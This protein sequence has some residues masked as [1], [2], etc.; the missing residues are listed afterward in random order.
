VNRPPAGDPAPLDR[1][2]RDQWGRVLAVLVRLLGDVDA[3][4]EAAAEAFAAAAERWPRD[5]TPTNPGSW[6]ITTAR[7]RAVDRARR[8]R[9]LAAKTEL[10]RAWHR[11]E[12]GQGDVVATDI[13]DERLELIFTCCH[14]ALAVE[15]QV[16]LTLRAVGGLAT[17]QIAR[18]F[19]VPEATMAQRLLRAKRKIRAAGIPFR[20]PPRHL[21]PERLDAVLAVIYLIFNE[22]YGGK[23]DLDGEALWLGTALADLLPEEAEVHGL[24]ALML[25]NDSRR[26]ARTCDGETVL[27]ADQDRLRWD[28]GQLTA[29]RRALDRALTLAGPYQ[30]GPY[31]LQALVASLHATDPPDWQ[32]IAILYTEL[33]R[34]TS[35]PVVAL[36]RAAA[37]GEVEGPA[38]GL[39]LV[40][41]LHL[42]GYRYYHATRA[43]LLRRLARNAEARAE[44]ERALD[45]TSDEAERRFLRRR[46]AEYT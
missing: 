18:A 21:L 8:D 15:A 10:L 20:V 3:A 38:A 35:S 26:E 43:D 28:R 22:G 9:T 1:V 11:G 30:K 12:E 14:P 32:G 24:L 37:V 25:L 39:E 4:E 40:D 17:A 31:V 36:N 34:L 41:S 5:G 16:P 23:D 6:L 46:L 27:L 42:D 33:Y 2:F 44:Y 7:N 13:R 19:L 45:A 29:G